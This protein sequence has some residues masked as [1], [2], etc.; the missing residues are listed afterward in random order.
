[1]QIENSFSDSF[2]DFVDSTFFGNKYVLLKKF[3]IFAEWI[4]V[5][6]L[7]HFDKRSV[8]AY[9]VNGNLGTFR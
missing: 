6:G 9:L 7:Q 3:F 4:R 5:I 1:M 8:Y 2:S